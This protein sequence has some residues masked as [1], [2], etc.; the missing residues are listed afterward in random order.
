MRS[1]TSFFRRHLPS[2]SNTGA[3][4]DESQSPETARDQSPPRVFPSSGFDIVK[5]SQKLEEE[6]YSWYSVKD[7]Y[8]AAIGEVFQNTYQVVAKLGYGTASTTWLCHDLRRHRYVALK[9]FA[10]RGKQPAREIAALEHIN[11]AL[12]ASQHVKHI[13]AD[14]IRT[15]LNQ[16]QISRPK[17]SRTHRCL[18]FDPLGASLAFCRKRVFGGRMSI[19]M[20][21]CVAFQILQ[22][23]DFLHREANLLHGDV[24]ED[25]I[26]FSVVE[27][28]EW[29]A[30]ED[31][32][33]VEPTP[34]KVYKDHAIHSTRMSYLP[35][36]KSPM[37][38]CDFGE[39]RFGSEAYSEHAMPDLYRAPEIL[40]RIQWNEKI[41]IWALG[42]V[43]WRLVEGTNLFTN[44]EGGR[45][46]SALPHMA[47]MISLLGPPPQHLLDSNPA[48][49]VYFDKTGK[50]KK[51]HKIVETSLEA[52]ATALEGETKAEF[53]RFLRRM[54]HWDQ[55]ER[56]SAQELLK[57]PWFTVT[58]LSDSESEA[59]E[60]EEQGEE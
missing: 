15:L 42:L 35:P 34:R 36:P 18:V 14:S 22:A 60:D 19:S 7:F 11:L 47:R 25:N 10:S 24:Q 3:K 38:L 12:A 13:G 32:E 51:G 39:A 6:N 5:P 50:L 41:D 29:R 27:A 58:D 2:A 30:V 46:K 53:L 43:L 55:D 37:V 26:M 56:P 4:T 20:V 23:L 9:I 33:M 44:N 31:A 52:E 16:F 59:G 21:K 57:D 49:K 17:S 45:W 48:T 40:L 8:P 28:S 54:L 1:L